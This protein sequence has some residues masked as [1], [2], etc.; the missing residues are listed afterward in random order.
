MADNIMDVGPVDM[1]TGYGDANAAGFYGIQKEL[2]R[3]AALARQAQQDA[4]EQ[5]VKQ[6][7]IAA[8]KENVATS[9]V[10]REAAAAANTERANKLG[11][12]SA[13]EGITPGQDLTPDQKAP[14][15]RFGGSGLVQSTPAMT[16][17]V[18]TQFAQAPDAAAAPEVPVAAA[19]DTYKGTADQQVLD[20]HRQYAQKVVDG[21]Q[22]KKD[23]GGELSPLEQEQ[24]YEGHSIL[25]TGKAAQ[26]P[27]GV[28][29]PKPAAKTPVETKAG[30]DL[31]VEK[32]FYDQH[33]AKGESPADAKVHA[34][35]DFN[36]LQGEQSA[37]RTNVT[38]NAADRRQ[39]A[40]FANKSVESDYNDLR[41]DYTKNVEPF[42]QRSVKAIDALTAPGGVNDVVA[43]PE[44]LS[45]MAG[46]QGSGL[47]MTQSELQMIQNARP[48]T[49]SVWIKLKNLA[50]DYTALTPAQREQMKTLVQSV[51]KHQIERGDRYVAA[52]DGIAQAKSGVDSH[53]IRTALM[54]TDLGDTRESLGMPANT[55]D[56]TPEQRRAR[57]RAAAG[58]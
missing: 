23:S 22:A 18:P 35:Q 52:M 28:I 38:V 7:Q 54:H 58:L 31:A 48:G 50:G 24:L 8:S 6:Q 32:I 10:Q 19:K 33:I 5:E 29:V 12:E 14:I 44:F 45:A 11:L 26:A 15:L 42:L 34:R 47:R 2:L 17:G 3:R 37:A 4:L 9:K 43:I 27:A 53:K 13:T 41:S 46:G 21:L 55:K 40:G 36:K 16:A 51:A 57:I 56:E 30:D 25:M 1:N 49:E 20:Q 39:E